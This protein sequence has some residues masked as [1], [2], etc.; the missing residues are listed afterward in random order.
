[1]EKWIRCF[2]EFTMFCFCCTI[3]MAKEVN[4]ESPYYMYPREK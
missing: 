3:G 2:W 1:M 4:L